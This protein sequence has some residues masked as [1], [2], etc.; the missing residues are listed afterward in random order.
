MDYTGKK[1]ILLLGLNGRAGTLHYASNISSNLAEYASVSLLLPSYSNT[2]IISKKVDIIKIHAPPSVIKTILL[3]FNIFQHIKA[4][5]TMNKI[6]ADVL[7]ILDIHPWYVMYWPF[8]KARKKVVTINDPELHSGES[9]I[10]MSFLLRKITR[11]LL[12]N[13]DEIIVLGKKQEKT[14]RKLGYKQR[15]I[16]SRIGHYDFFQKN[17]KKNYPQEKNT[18]LFFGRIKEYKGLRYLLEAIKFVRKRGILLKLIIAGEGDISSYKTLMDELKE[19]LELHIGYVPD[20]KVAELFQRCTFVVMPY[21]DAT[22]TGVVQVAYSFKKPVIATNVGSLPEV[23][24]DNKTGIIVPS[25]NS[26]AL[27]EAIIKMLNNPKDTMKKGL[28]AY[29]FM[30]KELDWKK[31][32]KE[33]YEKY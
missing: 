3:T 6:D 21:T 29:K 10:I 15:V 5:K 17:I 33:L 9:G 31:I 7:N 20:E 4:I 14:I 1:K 13:A 30:K 12:K 23:V 19:Y 8:I 22:Q 18:I 28:E 16:V 27:A 2:S 26:K 24:I 32:A 11:F 25:R